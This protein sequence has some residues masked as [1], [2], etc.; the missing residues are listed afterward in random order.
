MNSEQR[1]PEHAAPA[2]GRSSWPVPNASHERTDRT[3]TSELEEWRGE[4]PRERPRDSDGS[5]PVG[6][7]LA[8][9]SASGA[10]SSQVGCPGRR[11]HGGRGNGEIGH[12]GRAVPDCSATM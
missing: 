8:R 5:E 11:R 10:S 9:M 3:L 2:R 6:L 1:F 12:S 4:D 7:E